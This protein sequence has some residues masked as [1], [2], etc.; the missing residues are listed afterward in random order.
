MVLEAAA[1][2]LRSLEE[3]CAAEDE[4]MSPKVP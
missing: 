2:E 3:A 4:E 1:A